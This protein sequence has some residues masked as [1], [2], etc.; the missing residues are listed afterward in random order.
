MLKEN[1]QIGNEYIL[2]YIGWIQISKTVCLSLNICSTSSISY[3]NEFCK[4]L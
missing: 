2:R 1:K 3:V 4:E